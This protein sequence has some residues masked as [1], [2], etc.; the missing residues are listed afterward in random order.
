VNKQ[1]LIAMGAAGVVAFA[2][3]TIVKRK[4]KEKSKDE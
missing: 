1:N 3:V 4:F 2:V